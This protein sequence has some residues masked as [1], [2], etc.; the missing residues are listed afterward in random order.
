MWNPNKREQLKI[1]Q[2]KRWA[3]TLEVIDGKT[4]L[5][6]KDALPE[7]RADTI[8]NDI[9]LLKN[10]GQIRSQSQNGANTRVT[11]Y[12]VHK[13]DVDM[14]LAESPIAA[15]GGYVKVAEPPAGREYSMDDFEHR[16][17]PQKKHLV[18]VGNSM[19]EMAF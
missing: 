2:Q 15:W 4:R 9:A 11:Y 10:L 7:Y 1:E 18:Y 3:R 14:N 19:L 6:I 12:R 8:Y 13:V 5:Q 17:Y 16:Q